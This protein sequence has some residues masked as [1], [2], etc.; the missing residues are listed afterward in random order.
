M[1]SSAAFIVLIAVVMVTAP[2][3]AQLRSGAASVTLI[4]TVQESFSVRYSEVPAAEPF[5]AGSQSPPRALFLVLNWRLRPSSSFVVNPGSNADAHADS[6]PSSSGFVSLSR[7]G[8]SAAASSFLPVEQHQP[9]VLAKWGDSEDKPTG[10][11][12]I[13]VALPPSD[14]TDGQVVTVSVAAF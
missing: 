1:R 6:F 13:L 11:A 5:S 3:F 4:V 14:H 10:V 12:S 8:A 9:V 2:A 7:L